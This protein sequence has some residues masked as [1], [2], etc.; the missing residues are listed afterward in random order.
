MQQRPVHIHIQ[1]REQNKK[2]YSAPKEVI[3]LAYATQHSVLSCR[4]LILRILQLLQYAGM[5]KLT[6]RCNIVAM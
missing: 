4:M 1:H 6:Y 5:S 3:L 2:I